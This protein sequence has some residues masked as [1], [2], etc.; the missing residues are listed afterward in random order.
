VEFAPDS[1]RFPLHF[2]IP[3]SPIR[4]RN[5]CSVKGNEDWGGTAACKYGM[6]IESAVHCA[7]CC[8]RPSE[9]SDCGQP[10]GGVTVHRYDRQNADGWMAGPASLAMAHLQEKHHWQT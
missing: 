8:C 7:L 1:P 2:P 4:V 9:S 3:G 5:R 6:D 10:A